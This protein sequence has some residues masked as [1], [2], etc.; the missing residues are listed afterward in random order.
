MSKYSAAFT[1]LSLVMAAS[2]ANA[3]TDLSAFEGSRPDRAMQGEICNAII[4]QNQPRYFPFCATVIA[5]ELGSAEFREFYEGDGVNPF[6]T[7]SQAVQFARQTDRVAQIGKSATPCKGN[8]LDNCIAR[9]TQTMFVTSPQRE[10]E[11][12]PGDDL[13]EDQYVHL[14]AYRPPV[15]DELR[16]FEFQREREVKVMLRVSPGGNVSSVTI[17][18]RWRKPSLTSV[19]KSGFLDTLS[20][21]SNGC[22]RD[23]LEGMSTIKSILAIPIDVGE[24]GRF[25]QKTVAACGQNL[26]V[27]VFEPER[28]GLTDTELLITVTVNL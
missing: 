8:T 7:H 20:M 21:F 27:S 15:Y 14:S 26:S 25:G 6:L 22:G 16:R 13:V 5:T 3:Q 4:A 17:N 1:A 28:T 9:L 2:S 23:S 12:V 10:P 11:W 18:Q 24:G 19:L